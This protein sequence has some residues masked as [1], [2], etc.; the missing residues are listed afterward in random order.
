MEQVWGTGLAVYADSKQIGP[1]P[2]KWEDLRG[3]V[4]TNSTAKTFQKS[5]PTIEETMIAVGKMNFLAQVF[6]EA[7]IF[8]SRVKVDVYYQYI[9]LTLVTEILSYEKQWVSKQAGPLG[10]GDWEA[11]RRRPARVPGYFH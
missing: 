10:K 3:A 1:P 4:P 2:E 5:A 6:Y 9:P 11:V 7:K 8:S